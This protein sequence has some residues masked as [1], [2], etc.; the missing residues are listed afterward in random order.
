M[1]RK[2]LFWGCAFI[3]LGVSLLLYKFDLV[4]NEFNMFLN[5]WPVFLILAGLS[6][7]KIHEIA[8]KT[9]SG[10]AGVLLGLIVAGAIFS[11]WHVVRFN[12]F[13]NEDFDF[14]SNVCFIGD[15]ARIDL[16]SNIKTVDLKLNTSAGSF[17]VSDSGT[18]LADLVAVAQHTKV[19][20][21][22]SVSGDVADLKIS[23]NNQSMFFNDQEGSFPPSRIRL[24][25]APIWNIEA[26]TGAADYQADLS[27]LRVE[28]FVLKGGAASASVRF[29]DLMDLANVRI[30]AGASSV[31]L[32]VPKT[33]GCTIKAK[34]GLSDLDAEQFEKVGRNL[35]RSMNYDSTSKRIDIEIK[36]GVSHFMIERY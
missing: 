9:I 18:A 2:S 20:K 7:L 24:N 35:Y 13:D 21:R 36:G 32:S 15:T 8:R 16:D 3:T 12:V 17:I 30:K 27:R 14:E 34:T 19:F 11:G 1:T 31:K 23:I 33:V 10:L 29:G 6:L 26:R 22:Y 25:N 4:Q 5:L 28:S